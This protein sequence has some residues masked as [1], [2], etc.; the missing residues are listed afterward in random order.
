MKK[1]SFIISILIVLIMASCSKDTLSGDSFV[2]T[3][4]NQTVIVY[5]S[6]ENNLTGVA[7]TNLNQMIQGSSSLADSSNLIVFVDSADKTKAP[8][9]L[10]IKD[11][12]K[13]VDPAY[14]TTEDFY[15]SDPA[16]M[17]E[18][19]TWIM[20]R[21]PSDSYS[22]VLWGHSGGWMIT[23]DSVAWTQT[24]NAVRREYGVDTGNNTE[25]NSGMWINLP[26][27]ATVLN[28]LPH[29]FK[30]I[31]A[32]CCNFQCVESAYE[33]RNSAD[34]IIGSPAEIP[35]AGAPYTQILPSLFSD[36]DDFYKEL[37]DIYYEQNG[38]NYK[39]PMSV[40]KTSEMDNFAKAT[41]SMIPYLMGQ[42][43]L[44]PDTLV[45]YLH[46]YP[47][48]RKIMYDM[49]DVMLHYAPNTEAY[50]KWK[51]ALDKTVI[52]KRFASKWLAEE[53]YTLSSNEFNLTESKYGGISMFVPQKTYDTYGLSYNSDI[54]KMSWYYAV[55]MNNY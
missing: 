35:A 53:P 24:K 55:G 13:T 29:K 28:S 18:I 40:I 17:K 2:I 11:G 41:M 21:Y 12:K 9:I 45:Y 25:G 48:Y 36:K 50:N 16:K 6:A 51:S 37:T 31:L 22:L 47:S 7:T 26:S 42:D 27:L 20:N 54:K 10:R 4:A 39:V 15:A 14:T 5:M 34:Y 43:I 44:R 33:L 8:Y 19:L 30:Y 1:L 52:Y 46:A 32:D 23:K 3:P 49:N 38:N